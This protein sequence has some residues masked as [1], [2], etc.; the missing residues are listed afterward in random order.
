MKV[1]A[2]L[3]VGTLIFIV[4]IWLMDKDPQVISGRMPVPTE[5]D[6]NKSKLQDF[7][8]QRKEYIQNMH[9]AHPDMDWEKM[10]VESRKI[11]TEKVR[12]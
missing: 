1:C 3:L 8:Q 7:K 6:E 4:G 2:S 12:E 5:F 11:R 9:R 10:D